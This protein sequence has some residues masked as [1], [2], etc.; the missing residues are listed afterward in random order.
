VNTTKWQKEKVI[1]N[2]Y[3]GYIEGGF[4][5]KWSPSVSGSLT[6]LG[7]ISCIFNEVVNV[8][9]LRNLVITLIPFLRI[10]FHVSAMYLR[11]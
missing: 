1:A 10:E 7:W 5:C 3:S 11:S 9:V 2:K 4:D 8:S 6:N